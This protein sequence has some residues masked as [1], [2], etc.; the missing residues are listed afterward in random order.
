MLCSDSEKGENNSAEVMQIIINGEKLFDENGKAIHP[1]ET[2][3]CAFDPY[4]GAGE[5]G[6]DVMRTISKNTLMKD[7]KLVKIKDLFIAG[8]KEAEN[9]YPAGSSYPAFKIFDA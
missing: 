3:S 1:Q 4:I 8:I 9:K 2:I 6:F 5:L 7:N